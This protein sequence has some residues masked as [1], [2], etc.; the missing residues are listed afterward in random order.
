MPKLILDLTSATKTD[1]TII[2]FPPIGA[3]TEYFHDW[4][5]VLSPATSLRVVRLPGRQDLWDRQPISE[6]SRIIDLVATE[7]RLNPPNQTA[8][9]VGIC[10]TGLMAYALTHILTDSDETHIDALILNNTHLPTTAMQGLCKKFDVENPLMSAADSQILRR[11]FG[12]SEIDNALTA[13]GADST[14]R[15]SILDEVW[16][17]SEPRIRA[18]TL[19]VESYPYNL[20][21]IRVPITSIQ[22]RHDDFP[23]A[24][25]S[26]GWSAYTNAQFAYRELRSSNKNSSD[27]KMIVSEIENVL[28]ILSSNRQASAVYQHRLVD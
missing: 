27:A 9:V 22:T 11:S 13:D 4:L 16:Q 5:P 25:E 19:A 23:S 21:P 26:R 17:L 3:G 2:A 28:D 10:A 6:L 8:V 12:L 18:D 14:W 7:L 1:R 24:D 15:Q 20:N